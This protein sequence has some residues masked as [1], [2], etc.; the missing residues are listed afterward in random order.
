MC[1]ELVLL[2]LDE[3]FPMAR[4]ILSDDQRAI[5]PCFVRALARKL[6]QDRHGEGD[7]PILLRGLR[8]IGT[9]PAQ[10]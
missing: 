6:S 5:G 9:V 4:N 3:P 10:F 8:K 7:G 1:L 2:A